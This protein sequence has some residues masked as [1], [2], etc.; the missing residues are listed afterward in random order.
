MSSK[1]YEILYSKKFIKAFKKLSDIHKKMV[2]TKISILA[3]NPNYPS[4]RTKPIMRADDYFESSINMD[5]RVIWE[6]TG[7]RTISLTDV[8]HHDILDEY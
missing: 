7:V 1:K 2:L 5:I 8:G 4:L 3:D 6:F